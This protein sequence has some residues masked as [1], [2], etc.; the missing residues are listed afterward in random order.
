MAKCGKSHAAKADRRAGKTALKMT[1]NHISDCPRS[2][3]QMSLSPPT[4][5]IENI[6]ITNQILRDGIFHF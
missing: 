2:G 3:G 1:N 4:Y 5:L 6:N